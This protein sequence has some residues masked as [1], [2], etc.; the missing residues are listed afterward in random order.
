MTTKASPLLKTCIAFAKMVK[1]AGER[2]KQSLLDAVISRGWLMNA[3]KPS[4]GDISQ[5]AS[6]KDGKLFIDVFLG[7]MEREYPNG[8]PKTDQDELVY[9]K[10]LGTNKSMT[11]MGMKQGPDYEARPL[12]FFVRIGT[13]DQVKRLLMLGVNP[14]QYSS[15]FGTTPLGAAAISGK[16]SIVKAIL[17][18]GADPHVYTRPEHGGNQ[19]FFGSTMMHRILFIWNRGG[20]TQIPIAARRKILGALLRA[21]A[22]PMAVRHD[23]KAAIE[24]AGPEER[25]FL[26]N[27]IAKKQFLALDGNVSKGHNLRRGRL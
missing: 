10:C 3:I 24:E 12:D 6:D 22:D 18:S 8:I 5:G 13:A 23:G 7:V 14:N 4:V 25:A 26:E 17:E 11:F 27:Y 19:D 9:P 15:A 1:S 20:E 2:Q 16:A 21:G